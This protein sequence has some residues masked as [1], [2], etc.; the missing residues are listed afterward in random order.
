MKK[1]LFIL[2]GSFVLSGAVFALETED[3]VIA[4]L[5][6]VG[7]KLTSLDKI[8][9][10]GGLSHEKMMELSLKVVKLEEKEKKTPSNFRGI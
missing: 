6:A 1:I 7:D 3:A 9:M 2:I 8:L 5:Q 4:E 10:A